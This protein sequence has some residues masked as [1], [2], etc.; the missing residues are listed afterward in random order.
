MQALLANDMPGDDQQ[1][2]ESAKRVDCSDV[3]QFCA[4]G[5]QGRIDHRY[6][7]GMA[8]AWPLTHRQAPSLSTQTFVNRDARSK[9]LP[10]LSLPASL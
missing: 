5:F 10:S 7:V 2:R 3:W 8:D 4:D 1:N 9:G 6:R